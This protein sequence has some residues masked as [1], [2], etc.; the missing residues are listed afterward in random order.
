MQTLTQFKK[1]DF[2]FR[3]GEASVRVFW[4]RSGEIEV[5]R[6][7][8]SSSVLLGHVRP[9]EW[10]GEMGVIESRNRSAT[11]RA[12]AEGEVEVL[13]AQQFLDRVSSEPALDV[14]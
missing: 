7:V 1:G 14:S 9:G 13:N 3:Q 5:L 11:A 12:S 6:E 2:L 8:G 10:L 4:L